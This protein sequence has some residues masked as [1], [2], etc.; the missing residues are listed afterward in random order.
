MNL[1]HLNNLEQFPSFIK[2]ARGVKA[3]QLK[4]LSKQVKGLLTTS[5]AEGKVLA[6][7]GKQI[8][9]LTTQVAKSR[10]NAAWIGTGTALGGIGTGIGTGIGL[11]SITAPD[12]A[13]ATEATEA[14]A[15]T[16]E[17]DANNKD[18]QKEETDWIDDTA[19]SISEFYEKH[20][21]VAWGG[22]ALAGLGGLYGIYN[23]L[24][25]ED[26]EDE[27]Y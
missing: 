19:N 21:A 12:H 24:D 5:A 23:A 6:E 11:S 17:G 3:R 7:Q 16:A 15:A 20:P 14:T 8:K 9:D 1:E 4:E 2:Q 18:N 13:A 27:D 22:T 10:R 26:D 25:D